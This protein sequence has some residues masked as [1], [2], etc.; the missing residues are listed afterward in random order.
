MVAADTVAEDM[1]A[2]ATATEVDM[3][4]GMFLPLFSPTF[5]KST[6]EFCGLITKL[7]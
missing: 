7:N 3:A 2:E 5:P 6:P 1:V 4:T